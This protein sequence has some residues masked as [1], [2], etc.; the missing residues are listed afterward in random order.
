VRR[1]PRC[2]VILDFDGTLV[3]FAERPEEVRVPA[4]LKAILSRLAKHKKLYLAIL[5]G[6]TMRD[7]Q[8]LLDVEGLKL[9]GLHGSQEETRSKSLSGEAKMALEATSTYLR[10]WFHSLPEVWIEDKGMSFAVH[11]RQASEEV[12]R[13]AWQIV[14]QAVGPFRRMLRVL[15]GELV[16]EVLPRELGDKGA[17]IQR[18]LGKRSPGRLGIYLGDDPTDEPAFEALK[19]GI[20]IHVGNWEGTRAAYQLPDP[21]AARRLLDML[22]KELR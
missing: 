15:E 3:D 12:A 7:L 5:S 2:A 20:T 17:A 6:R 13:I 11:Y 21:A 22:E 14:L 19:R 9:Y 1:A 18:L 10:A 4:E 8:K 16:W